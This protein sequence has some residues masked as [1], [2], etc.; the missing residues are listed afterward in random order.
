MSQLIA[1]A[2]RADEASLASWQISIM[3]DD[4]ERDYPIGVTVQRNEGI[5]CSRAALPSPRDIGLGARRSRGSSTA[6]SISR[7]SSTWPPSIGRARSTARRKCRTTCF[8]WFCPVKGADVDLVPVALDQF[9]SSR[10]EFVEWF[11]RNLT[12]LVGPSGVGVASAAAPT[13]LCPRREQAMDHRRCVQA[14]LAPARWHAT[15]VP[16]SLSIEPTKTI[17]ARGRRP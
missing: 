16:F 3:K 15:G 10:G 2:L 8:T 17:V 5:F 11:S 9:H 12:R 7:C 13:S 1:E 4:V 14:R 6:S